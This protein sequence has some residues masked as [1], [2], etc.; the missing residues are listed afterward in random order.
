MDNIL[1]ASGGRGVPLQHQADDEGATS[2]RSTGVA[3]GL[4]VSTIILRVSTVILRVSTVILI[5]GKYSYTEGKYS[6][7]MGKYSYTAGK[8]NYTNK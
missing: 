3:P 8:Y 1:S 5:E 2:W 4:W 7:T 6:Y